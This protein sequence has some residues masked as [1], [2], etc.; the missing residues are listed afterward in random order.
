MKFVLLNDLISEKTWIGW[1]D[2]LYNFELEYSEP[3][4]L[5]HFKRN[6]ID[7]FYSVLI[8][9]CFRKN[10]DDQV[11]V[12]VYIYCALLSKGRYCFVYNKGFNIY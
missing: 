7:S 9:I 1:Q 10:I 5:G 8:K 4:I 12:I 6:A 3:Y 2:M 11:I